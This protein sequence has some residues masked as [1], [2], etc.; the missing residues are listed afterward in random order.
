M[1]TKA[2]V[3][4]VMQDAN[5]SPVVGGKVIASLVGSDFF[6]D[7][8]RIVTQKVSAV[9]DAQGQWSMPLI[10][11][12]EG[13]NNSTSWTV[14]GYDALLN[15]VFKITGLF[16]ASADPITLSEL[17]KISP[18]NQK[19]AKDEDMAFIFVVESYQEYLDL[20]EGQRR[21]NDIILE[22]VT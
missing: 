14:D 11:N 21:A 4:G 8:I 9:T 15:P 20:P 7:G 1:P 17:E 13:D 2:T 22:P 18:Q 19:A 16:I 12:R 5:L 3:S 6:D 10:V